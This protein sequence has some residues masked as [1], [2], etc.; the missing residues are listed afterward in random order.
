[1]GF[2]KHAGAPKTSGVRIDYGIKSLTHANLYT[3]GSSLSITR[4]LTKQ[5]PQG[6]ELGF[7]KQVFGITMHVVSARACYR[8][9]T[10]YS[11]EIEHMCKL[12]T[13]VRHSRPRLILCIRELD[14][15]CVAMFPT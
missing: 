6:I 2:T 8:A 1:M 14:A 4:Q 3:V 7:S 13:S 9:G 10:R 15:H 11:R 12:T 5:G